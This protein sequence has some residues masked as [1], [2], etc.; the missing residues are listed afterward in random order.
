MIAGALVN[1]ADIGNSLFTPD[2]VFP[3]AGLSAEEKIFFSTLPQA[4]S[5][6]AEMMTRYGTSK[7]D[8]VNTCIQRIH[9][10]GGTN[11]I[12][13]GS[14]RRHRPFTPSFI[15]RAE[16]QAYILSVLPRQGMQLGYVHKDGLIMR[17]DK[18][19]FALDAIEAA[20]SG[21][22]VGD[23]IRTLFFSEY[24]KAI[25]GDISR[26]KHTVDPFTGCFISIIPKTVVFLR[27][28][29]KAAS[30]FASG[31]DEQGFDF[32]T[33]GMRRIQTS[34]EFMDEKKGRLSKSLEKERL[35]WDIYYDVLDALEK[36]LEEKD[37]FAVKLQN[38]ARA[39]MQQCQIMKG[40]DA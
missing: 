32:V 35:G 21:K 26:L 12:W 27:F 8:G 11:G 17:H 5:T 3:R 7:L 16:D 2:V 31:K 19:A 37:G 13:V 23:Y 36:G 29:L 34:L 22:L 14:L 40:V 15:G 24:A 9:V 20:S 25:A 4:L 38:K 1:E 39:I 28:C 33:M 30:F 6:E 18:K 10:T